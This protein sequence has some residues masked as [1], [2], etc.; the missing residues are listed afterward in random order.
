MAKSF[1]QSSERSEDNSVDI[2]RKDLHDHELAVGESTRKSLSTRKDVEEGL[3]S[4]KS[5][6]SKGKRKASFGPESATKRPKK[7]SWTSEAVEILLK[8]IKEFK[9]KC[10]FYGVNFEVN[11]SIMDTE[12][13]RCMAVDFLEDFGSEIVQEPGSEEYEFYRK[14]LEE[15]KRQIRNG[16][17]RIKEK[18]R[19]LVVLYLATAQLSPSAPDS[20]IAIALGTKLCK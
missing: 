14:E 18:V 19:H 7:W 5:K 8:Y 20:I 9:T 17:Q 4:E 15:Q 11:I 16:Y 2:S 1:E 10:E 3:P 13:R 6:R 12:I